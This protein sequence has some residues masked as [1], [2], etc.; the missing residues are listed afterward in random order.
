MHHYYN[1]FATNKIIMYT[2]FVLCDV[3]NTCVSHVYLYV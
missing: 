2:I 3:Q 1:I